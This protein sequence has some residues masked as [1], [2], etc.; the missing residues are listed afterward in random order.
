[1]FMHSRLVVYGRT[2]LYILHNNCYFWVNDQISLGDS[3]ISCFF[4]Y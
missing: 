3:I 1:M 4:I 2:T